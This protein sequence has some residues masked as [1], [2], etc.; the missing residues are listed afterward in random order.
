MLDRDQ[1][2]REIAHRLWE[3]EGRPSDQEKRHWA[4]AERIFDAQEP[5]SSAGLGPS[6]EEAQKAARPIGIGKRRTVRKGSKRGAGD[7]INEHEGQR[8]WLV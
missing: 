3:E 1:C 4:T 2:V 8:R 7:E 5:V 6:H